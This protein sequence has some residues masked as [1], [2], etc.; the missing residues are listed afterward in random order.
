MNRVLVLLLLL[1]LGGVQLHSQTYQGTI[2]PIKDDGTQTDFTVDVA[3]LSPEILDPTHGLK[4]VCINLTHTWVSDLDIRLIAP[5]G[6]NIMLASGLGG[7]GD[8]YQNTCFRMDAPTH[9]ITSWWPFTGDFIP[10]SNIGNMNDGQNGNGQW[11]LRILDTYAY[12]D[13]GDMLDWQLN[14]EDNAPAPDV[15]GSTTLPIFILTTDG[16]NTIPD[17]PKI[18][19]NLK[20]INNGTGQLNHLTDTPEFDGPI[21]IEVRG[22]SSQSFPKKNFGFVTRD[23][24]GDDLNVSLLGLPEEKSW[25]FYAPY[26]DKSFLRDALTYHLGNA[27]GHYTS[28]TVFGEM[29]LNGDYQ[30]VYCLEEKIKRDKNRVDIAKLNPADTTGD[31]LTGGYLLKV[32]RDDG[33]GSYFVSNY[34]GTDTTA[35]VR[36]VFEDPEGPKMTQV[37]RDYIQNFFNHFEDALYGKD[38]KDEHLGYRRYVDMPSLVDY[39]LVSE[40]GH[41][42][43]AYRLSTYM[44]KDRDSI[45]SLLH[46]GPLWDFNLAYGNVDYCSC[47]SIEGWTYINSSYCGNTPLWW[48]RFV[49]DSTFNAAVRCRY[50]EL[51][52]TVLSTEHVL[53]YMDS[54]AL[55]FNEAQSRNYTKWPILGIYIWPNHFIGN[56]YQEEINYMKSWIVGRLDWMDENLPGTCIISGVNDEAK[57]ELT[58]YPN[59]TSQSFTIR[60]SDGLPVEGQLTLTDL[61]GRQIFS[62]PV[63]LDNPTMDVAQLP[64]GIY[65]VSF[66]RNHNQTY[67]QKIVVAR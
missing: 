26:T 44:Y 59:P 13:A 20:V 53:H 52:E 48:L 47:E 50:D 29:F 12:A 10:F 49:Q 34:K 11:T 56:T 43:D 4:S 60:L 32:D 62:K 42:V 54:M 22:A 57:N 7:D 18:G 41:N 8:A 1:I 38:F 55:T 65:I 46:F 67:K 35:E 40:L 33:A 3:G 15:F 2:G 17:Q 36:I 5:D 14:F 23:E 24:N 16:N 66:T 6:R 28:R 64:E 19:A 39:F 61:N 45:D 58:L 30:G 63:N 37:Q 27:T 51:R 31:Q 21:G 25:I 9:I